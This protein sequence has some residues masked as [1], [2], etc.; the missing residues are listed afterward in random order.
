MKRRTFLLLSL[1]ILVGSLFLS[2]SSPADKDFSF[3]ISSDQRFHTTVPFQTGHYTLP[4]YEA[5]KKLGQGAFMVVLGDIDPPS[6]T[7]E[8]M[9]KVFGKDYPWYVVR[10]NH[11]TENPSME[12][13]RSLNRGE[14]S[15]QHVVRKGPAGSEET[16]YSFDWN[17]VHFV[18][19][20]VF[21]DGKSDNART[22]NI[23]PE[24]LSW[25]E[26]DLKQNKKEHTFVFGHVPL[27]SVLDMDNGTRRHTGEVL[28]KFPDNELKFERVLF[29]YHVT[30]YV[31]GHIHCA[32]YTNI[33]GLWLLNDGHIYGYEDTYTPELLFGAMSQA[34]EK[35]KKAGINQSK[36]I[37]DFFESDKKEI[38]NILYY[39]NPIPGKDYKDLTDEESLKAATEFYANYQKSEAAAKEYTD[40]FWKNCGW[41]SSTFL[42]VKISGGTGVVEFYRDKDFNG[43]YTLRHTLTL[44]TK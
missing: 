2:G 13:I 44:F 33:N 21:F 5:I 8:L 39:L 32:S 15:F 17:D 42:R 37:A 6:A 35:G 16:T 1:T 20:N 34:V 12:Y 36:A 10:G 19:L 24:L 7:R 4:G 30:A 31:S 40:T 27:F 28:D 29:K 38:K 9:D 23:V 25:L 11:D 26:D 41:R 43:N 22:P 14:K 3:I 18:V